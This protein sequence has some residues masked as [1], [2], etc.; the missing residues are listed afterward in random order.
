MKYLI[1]ILIHFS[2]K[3]NRLFENE[4]EGLMNMFKVLFE[5]EKFV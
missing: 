5:N 3:S 4:R 1:N 2:K